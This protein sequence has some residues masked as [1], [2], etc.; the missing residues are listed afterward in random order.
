MSARILPAVKPANINAD[1]EVG[2]HLHV[3]A[4]LWFKG[5]MPR[6]F[7]KRRTR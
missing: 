2:A 4:T 3:M 5:A 6:C 1:L 7:G